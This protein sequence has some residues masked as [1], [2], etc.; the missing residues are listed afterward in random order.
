MTP[1]EQQLRKF[2]RVAAAMVALLGA[3][4]L[5][6]WT[7]DVEL[8]KSLMHPERI[9][10]NPVTALSLIVCA[11]ALWLVRDEPPSPRR[12]LA[13]QLLGAAVT[14][15][16]AS[17]LCGYA[18]DWHDGIDQL[19][20][21]ARLA[22]NVMAPNT[23]ATMLVVGLVFVIFDERTPRGYHPSQLLLI[24][25]AGVAMFSLAG[26][27]YRSASLYSMRGYIPMAL[28]T[29]IAFTLLCIGLLCARPMRE[30]V[31]TF[32]SDTLGGTMARRL[33]PAALVAPLLFGWLILRGARIGLYEPESGLALLVLANIVIFNLIVWWS[34]HVV[35]ASDTHR[36]LSQEVLR[37]NEER[38]RAVMEQAAEGI[39]LVDLATKHL[40]DSNAA[41]DRLLGYEPGEA[42]KR[43]V[44]DLVDDTPEHVD[45]R[46]R[47]LMDA[48]EPMHGERQYRR[49]DGSHVDVEVSATV[50]A[51]GGRRVAC[52]VVHD[53]SER[54]RTE[55]ELQEK[56][57]LL[58]EAVG[59]ER[60]A[61][62]KLRQA[63]ERSRV[64][65]QQAADAITLVDAQTLHIVDVNDAFTRLLGYTRD[66]LIDLP[67]SN[68]IVDTV[69][70][71]AAQAQKTVDATGMNIVQRQYR[72]KDGS[73][74]DVEKNAS[75]LTLN[76]RRVLS[77]V[78]HD[79][80]DRNR[81]ERA[82]HE[83]HRQLEETHDQLKRAQSQLVQSE[84]LAG[85][86]QMVAGVA[87]E[88]NNPL[89]FVSNNVAVLQ[90]D[91]KSL[92]E[93]LKLYA[94]ADEILKE[95]DGE[96]LK[97]IRDLSDRV[98][99][100]Y[101]IGNLDEMLVRSRDG[102]RRIQQIVKDLRDFARLD[103]SDL[104][105]VDINAGIES[106]VN[107]IQ[108]HAKKKRI[109]VEKHLAPLPLVMCNPAKVNQ[110]VMNLVGNAIDASPEGG[111]V[112]IA[113]TANGNHVTIDVSDTGTGVPDTIRE[114][115]FDPFFTTKPPGE[116]TGLGLSISYGIVKD[117]GGSIELVS[118][119]G[120][121]ARFVVTLPVDCR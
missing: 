103:E 107:I 121:G 21:R 70:G 8:L 98:D 79:V 95:R 105:H 111:R 24:A 66:E 106:T 29:A 109:S 85:L 117:H 4:V 101:T 91:T 102:L 87:H 76:G 54:K 115:I 92:C 113:T 30:P 61:L 96:L 68:F 3:L 67:I 86:G 82:L 41:L 57:R 56:N 16:A 31:A 9:A 1:H 20:F 48:N 114:R 47:R 5:L 10:M 119:P 26:Y 35:H 120:E 28:N 60:D 51:Y 94:K 7:L 6:G 104:H 83:K 17:R 46:L 18:L 40:L 81:A 50:I 74:V 36:R 32:V 13:A 69:E 72:R 15:V 65:V 80:T 77:T 37:Q 23:A 89:A 63:E 14:V 43:T 62:E 19:L 100:A 52:T 93:L 42:R 97:A 118:A 116:G 55:R 49:K 34:S 39:Y 75:I 112:T 25:A 38:H 108:G 45:A 33:V 88:I 58:E 12:R 22:G 73:I 90:R 78:I 110:V 53:I 59:A 84:K 2:P 27:L 64:I 99:L 44:Y 71:V 11:V